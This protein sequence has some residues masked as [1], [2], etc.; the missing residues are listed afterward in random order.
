MNGKPMLLAEHVSK[1]YGALTVLRDIN[2][3]LERSQ[4]LSLVGPSGSGK[5]TFLRCINSLET[6]EGGMIWVNGSLV[7]YKQVGDSYHELTERELATQ[8]ATCGMVFQSY[9]LFPHMTALENIIEAPVHVRKVPRK[10]AIEE[11]RGLLAAVGLSAKADFYPRQLSGG[12][13]QRVAIARALAM[14]PELMLFDEPT[15]AL[16]PQLV[17]EVL[18]VM[19]KLADAGTTMVVVTHELEFAREISDFVAFMDGGVIVEY[20]APSQVLVDPL[21]GR[22]RAFIT[23]QKSA[24]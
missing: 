18:D 11:A 16:D 2:L 13:Q 5:S 22:T 6:I 1:S 24:A 21:D 15:S 8:R 10:Q 3:R 4:V 7:G 19:R 20:G 9:N 14:K 12:Q 23:R 17:G